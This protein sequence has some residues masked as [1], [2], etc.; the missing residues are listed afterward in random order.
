MVCPY[1]NTAAHGICAEGIEWCPDCGTGLRLEPFVSRWQDQLQVFKTPYNR[2]ARFERY[3]NKF[4][5]VLQYRYAILDLFSRFEFC[6]IHTGSTRKYF[7]SKPVML[8]VCCE[9]LQVKAV[10]PFLK[11]QTR[12]Q[13]QVRE[14]Q[15][16]YKG[17]VWKAVYGTLPKSSF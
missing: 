12:E 9:L 15:K 13:K 1:C 6:W 7:F 11:S 10:L 3:L 8:K 4:P 14:L 17:T 2:R 16:L 5:A